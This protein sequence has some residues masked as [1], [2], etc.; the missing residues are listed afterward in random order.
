MRINSINNVNYKY[1][2]NRVSNSVTAQKFCDKT[3]ERNYQEYNSIPL[4]SC[5]RPS[6]GLFDPA[7]IIAGGIL[8]SAFIG[9][10]YQTDRE[11][12]KR[13]EEQRRIREKRIEDINSASQKMNITREEAANYVDTFLSYASIKPSN[14]GHEKGMNAIIGYGYEKYRLASE[15]ICPIIAKERHF[16]DAKIPNG[17]LL[18]GPPGGGKT[19][20]AAK[21]TEHLDELG[22]NT[23]NVD[24]EH[25]KYS[26]NTEKIKDAFKQAE[27]YYKKT[28]YYTV[29]N[30][31]HDID[32][33]LIDRNL[34]PKAMEQVGAF[35]NCSED[36]A[37]KGAIWI[38]TA[39]N[40]KL[41]DKAVL[42]PG[43]TDVKIPI[44]EMQNF[45][46]ADMIKYALYKHGEKESAVD[47]DYKKV[48]DTI[49]KNNLKYTPA[50]YELFI[51]KAKFY[52]P[53]SEKY[54]TADMFINIMSE[55]N[56][57]DFPTLD[58]EVRK[59]F[60]SDQKYVNSISVETNK[61][62]A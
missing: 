18:Y 13:E 7:T 38:S 9:A 39:N 54:I 11:D 27:E 50:E 55:Y 25:G 22:V 45:E 3:S 20:I 56:Q 58:K 31:V 42:R 28:G 44:G 15:L 40:P 30:F 41:I 57:T 51:K 35:I 33:I 36:C 34:N 5:Y 21:V 46:V 49:R 48:T 47:F 43:R 23:L 52:K 19:Y 10:A 32:N 60:K 6:F 8:I 29:I 2:F 26:E 61:Q 17:V 62:E 14:D 12:K 53:L 1:R 16:S 37:K 24:L 4:Q 59:K